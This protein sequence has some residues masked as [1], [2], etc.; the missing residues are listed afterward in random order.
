[1]IRS[2]SHLILGLLLFTGGFFFGKYWFSSNYKSNEVV[3]I[4]SIQ[5]IS[6]WNTLTVTKVRTKTLYKDM[7]GMDS[8]NPGTISLKQIWASINKNKLTLT[9]PI[10]AK[11]GCKVDSISTWIEPVGRDSV[12]ITLPSATL[13]SLEV[14]LDEVARQRELGL[15]AFQDEEFMLQV[16]STMYQDAKKTLSQRGNNH[17]IAE[18]KLESELK[19][20]YKQV[21]VKVGVT[22]INPQT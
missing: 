5:E 18:R 1:M 10:V 9:V 14:L 17:A 12:H 7:D 11:F 4:Q 6:E 22:F 8:R 13:T 19:R 2:V 21:G 15:F 3:T 20:F 16:Q